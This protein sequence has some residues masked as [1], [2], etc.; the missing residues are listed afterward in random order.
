[1][2][3]GGRQSFVMARVETSG[4]YIGWGMDPICSSLHCVCVSAQELIV[5]EGRGSQ[6]NTDQQYLDELVRPFG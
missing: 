4:V 1:M 5:R 2:E 3:G 6:L